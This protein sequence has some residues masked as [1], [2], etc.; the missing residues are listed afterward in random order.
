RALRHGVA[1]E[2]TVLSVAPRAFLPRGILLTDRERRQP[3]GV[4]AARPRDEEC[5]AP[6]VV[7]DRLRARVVVGRV[8][9]LVAEQVRVEVLERAHVALAVLL[10]LDRDLFEVDGAVEVDRV[11]AAPSHAE[12]PVADR[13]AADDP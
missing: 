1:R 5:A 8:A 3:V 9:D 13:S 2:L 4:T 12:T 11:P 7:D 6:L 10:V